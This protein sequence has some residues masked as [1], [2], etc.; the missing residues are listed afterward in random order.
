MSD[1]LGGIIRAILAAVGGFILAKGWVSAET[2]AWLT[3]GVM[4]I[5]PAIWSWFTN[6]PSAMAA[7]VQNITG[8][9]VQTT[10]S[11]PEAVKEAVAAAKG[12]S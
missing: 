8:V 1:Q 5:G 4:T 9:N 11:A 2:W 12:T 10:A 7:T 3:G 6:R